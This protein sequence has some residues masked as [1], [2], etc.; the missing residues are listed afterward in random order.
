[1]CFARWHLGLTFL[2]IFSNSAK[3][4]REERAAGRVTLLARHWSRLR[5]CR[6]SSWGHRTAAWTRHGRSH[7]HCTAVTYVIRLIHVSRSS[8]STDSRNRRTCRTNRHQNTIST[9]QVWYS[10]GFAL[11]S[12][13]CRFESRPGILRTKVYLAFHPSGGR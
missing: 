3:N 11:Q 2:A 8:Q 13:G 4:R 9:T 7:T 1:M 12:G 5:K 10:A 6:Q